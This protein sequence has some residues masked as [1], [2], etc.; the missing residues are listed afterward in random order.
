MPET[1]PPPIEPAVA[2]PPVSAVT[3]AV[4]PGPAPA[5]RP[6]DPFTAEEYARFAEEDG[7]AG[8][9][10][11]WLLCFLFVYTILVASA[12]IWWTLNAG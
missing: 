9:V 5:A 1:A 7:R 4:P 8:R 6:A 3:D 2:A 10:I 11:G 12:A